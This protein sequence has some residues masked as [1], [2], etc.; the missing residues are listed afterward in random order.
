VKLT[1]IESG[2]ILTGVHPKTLIFCFTLSAVSIQ[3]S[4]KGLQINQSADPAM[5]GLKAP[6]IDVLFMDGH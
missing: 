5:A 4:A 2:N 1:V 3:L 6:S